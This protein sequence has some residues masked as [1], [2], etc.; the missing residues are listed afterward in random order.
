MNAFIDAWA[1]LVVFPHE[2]LEIE[3]GD[4]QVTFARLDIV[5]GLPANDSKSFDTIPP[6]KQSADYVV[7]KRIGSP[8][9]TPIFPYLGILTRF[10]GGVIHNSI[11]ALFKGGDSN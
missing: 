6:P 11:C 1:V 8:E 10:R 5:S 7:D 2:H 4:D 9:T 3:F